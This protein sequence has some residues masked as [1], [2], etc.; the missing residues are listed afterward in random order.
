MNF[1]PSASPAKQGLGWER[2][3]NSALAEYQNR[4]IFFSLIELKKCEGA[5]KRMF[6]KFF[7]FARRSKAEAGGNAG[8]G[9]N[10][11]NPLD[12]AQRKFGFRPTNTTITNLP[13]F[14]PR[15]RLRLGLRRVKNKGNSK[16]F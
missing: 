6:R 13:S 16:V 5:I 2:F 1:C 3:R 8:S 12:F 4:K 9:F 10:P 14:P 11:Q 7:C 15:P